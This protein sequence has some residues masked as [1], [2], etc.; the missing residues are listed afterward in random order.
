MN[1][2]LKT[3]PEDA[4]VTTLVAG[5]I[6]DAQDLLKQQ[7][8][9]LRHEVRQDLRKAKEAGFALGAGACVGLVGIFLVALMLVFILQWAVPSLP[10]WAC[11]GIW[12]LIFCVAG[13]GLCYAGA[14]TIESIHPLPDESVQ[15][16]KENVQWITKKT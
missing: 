4:S 2:D 15:A 8:D 16:L 12:G 1:A 14:L 13:G 11:F 9:L 5:I 3:P 6:H 7:I 10:L